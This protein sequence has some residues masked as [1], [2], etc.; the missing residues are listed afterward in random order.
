MVQSHKQEG[1]R[2]YHANKKLNTAVGICN[3]R[4][5]HED[6]KLETKLGNTVRETLASGKEK[7]NNYSRAE[8]IA[9]KVK[10]LLW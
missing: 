9:Q 10:S 5:R 3:P 2:S 6:F 7:Q 1:L 8:E 4:L